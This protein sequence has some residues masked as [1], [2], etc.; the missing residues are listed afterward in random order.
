[1]TDTTNKYL[2]L[3][4]FLILFHH[5]LLFVVFTFLTCV[6]FCAMVIKLSASHHTHYWKF[7]TNNCFL[8][9]SLRRLCVAFFFSISCFRMRLCVSWVLDA[10]FLFILIHFFFLSCVFVQTSEAENCNNKIKKKQ[11]IQI[12][13]YPLILIN[14][15]INLFPSFYRVPN[16]NLC[17]FLIWQI[18]A[19]I[20]ENTRTA[21]ECDGKSTH[22]SFILLLCFFVFL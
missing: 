15:T 2:L 20:N 11:Q 4:L 1:M 14:K 10:F 21:S 17:F 22:S 6:Q 5:F 7:R 19:H 13:N 9:I 8:F 3:S 12:E 16:I 18:K